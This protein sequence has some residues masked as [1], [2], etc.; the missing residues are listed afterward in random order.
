[1][2]EPP[3]VVVAPAPEPSPPDPVV[4]ARDLQAA[5]DRAG[6]NPGTPDGKWGPRSARAMVAFNRNAGT[7]LPTD[8]ATVEA[9][10]AVA[11]ADGRICAA[12]AVRQPTTPRP[13]R[14][15]PPAPPQVPRV[16]VPQPVQPPAQPRPAAPRAAPSASGDCRSC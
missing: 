10:A 1:L 2:P 4:L 5:L 16:T 13:P 15:T 11:A 6:C 12:A 3:R 7:D 8:A 9:L 14:A